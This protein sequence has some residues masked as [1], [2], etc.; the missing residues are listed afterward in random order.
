MV[1][2]STPDMRALTVRERVL[3]LCVGSDTDWQRAGVMSET[4]TSLVVKGLVMRDA[5]G[6]LVLTN[7]GR[8]ALRALLP[9]L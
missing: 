7:S 4:V 6:R 3:L 5:L 1:K 9:E 8:A 2:R